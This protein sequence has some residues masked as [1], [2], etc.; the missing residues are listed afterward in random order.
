MAG[1]RQARQEPRDQAWRSP[2]LFAASLLLLGLLVALCLLNHVGGAFRTPENFL[3][4]G[5][6][7]FGLT[8]F[9]T[10]PGRPMPA[11]APWLVGAYLL[12]LFGCLL[13]SGS[14]H[15][16]T[17]LWSLAAPPL[18]FLILGHRAGLW[19][20]GGFLA[21]LLAALATGRPEMPPW[22][23]ASLVAV[24]VLA[25]LICYLRERAARGALHR[26][27][28]SEAEVRRLEGLLRLCGWCHKRILDDGGDWVPLERFLQDRA[29]V[30]VSHSIC[31]DCHASAAAEM[32]RRP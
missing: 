32:E 12:G 11:W 24:F 30:R 26:A 29:P 18:V 28:R 7:V 3:L 10:R 9:V 2:A 27:A 1:T 5:I 15:A 16:S 19:L 22:D 4:P 14:A 25:S 8:A 13:L 23:A 6:A 17:L 20:C 31:P 21:M